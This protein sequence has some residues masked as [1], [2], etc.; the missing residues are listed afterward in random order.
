MR[1][2][3]KQLA[4]L[5]PDQRIYYVLIR[6]GRKIWNRLFIYMYKAKQ[7][8]VPDQ[9]GMNPNLETTQEDVFSNGEVYIYNQLYHKY[10]Y[11]QLVS[12]YLTCSVSNALNC[13]EIQMKAL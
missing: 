12:A 10:M 2:R 6:P 8:S 7:D 9:F 5:Q 11:V 13:K 1:A 4:H 3:E